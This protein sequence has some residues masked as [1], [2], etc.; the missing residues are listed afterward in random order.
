M[1]KRT[2]LIPANLQGIM[3]VC[4]LLMQARKTVRWLQLTRRVYL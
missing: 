1:R 3:A 2:D 4:H